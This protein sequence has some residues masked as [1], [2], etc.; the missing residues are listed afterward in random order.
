MEFL[1]SYYHWKFNYITKVVLE[2][3]NSIGQLVHTL[4]NKTIYISAHMN[5]KYDVW[6]VMLRTNLAR[7]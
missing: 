6:F 4:A 5:K 1:N 2:E 7:K 3:K